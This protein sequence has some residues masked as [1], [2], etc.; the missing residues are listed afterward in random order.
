VFGLSSHHLEN[1]WFYNGGMKFPS[2]VQDTTITLYGRRLPGED[3]Y[4]EAVGLDFVAHTRELID[5]YQPQLIWF[6]WTVAKP[7]IQPYFNQFLA[8]YYNNALDWGKGVVVNTKSGYPTNVQVGDVERGKLDSMR[9]YPWQTDTSV[10]KKSWCYIDG[11]ENKTAE[12]IVHDL[13]DIVSK[14]GN[15]L[16]NIG[17]RADGTITDEQKSVLLGIGKWLEVNGDAIYGT[18]CWKKAGEGNE[19]GTA[20]SFSD[21]ESTPY[22]AED[23]RFTAKGNDFYAIVL[24]WDTKG[25]LIK[26]LTPEAIADAKI[27]AVKLLGSDAPIRYEQTPAGLKLFFPE[28]KPCDYAYSFRITFD[29]P[30]GANLPSEMIDVPFKHGS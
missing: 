4:D 15:L 26:S 11:E 10:G 23:M 30:V 21:N 20:G 12:Q 8:Y 24:N 25:V 14:N 28:A 7:A 27:T 29:S 9:K 2:D 3:S 6:D 19:A 13:I 5:K 16:L 1:N 17:P 22:T 18:R